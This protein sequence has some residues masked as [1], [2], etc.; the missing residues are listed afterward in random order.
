MPSSFDPDSDFDIDIP[1][2]SP[3]LDKYRYG[4]A[5]V[6]ALNGSLPV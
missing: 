1:R 5:T 4:Q 6:H 2:R 3:L